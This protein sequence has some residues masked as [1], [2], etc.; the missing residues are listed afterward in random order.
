MR[1]NKE[2]NIKYCFR[3]KCKNCP[4][5]R[6]CEEELR[7]DNNVKTKEVQQSRRYATRH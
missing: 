7:G 3:Y 1:K 5:Q 4:R 6:E 2:E